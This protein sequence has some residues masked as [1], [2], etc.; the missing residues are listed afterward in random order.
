[1]INENKKLN[2]V[3]SKKIF[4]VALF[5]IGVIATQAQEQ[6]WYTDVNE[7]IKVSKKVKKPL[8]LFFTGL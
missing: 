5:F 7:A 8:M 6:K 4:F 3:M 2:R 1:M